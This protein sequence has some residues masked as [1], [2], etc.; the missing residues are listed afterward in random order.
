M[1]TIRIHL[2]SLFGILL[3]CHAPLGW[4]VEAGSDHGTSNEALAKETIEHL[5]SRLNSNDFAQRE[6]ASS[7]L[8]RRGD[9]AIPLLKATAEESSFLEA[10]TRA[11]ELVQ[12]LHAPKRNFDELTE[13]ERA[14]ATSELKDS[15]VVAK[16]MEPERL[17]LNQPRPTQEVT[18]TYAQPVRCGAYDAYEVPH[19]RIALPHA[20]DGERD[21]I[22]SP[23]TGGNQYNY[24]DPKTMSVG[25]VLTESQ[26]ELSLYCQKERLTIPLGKTKRWLVILDDEGTLKRLAQIPEAPKKVP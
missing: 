16:Q 17:D 10:S 19:L 11:K 25:V 13:A 21:L 6:E 22:V 4:A 18:Y 20:K 26:G 24:P 12:Y 1:T 7:E 5:I 2:T 9:A 23:A 8:K 3:L 15:I 14:V